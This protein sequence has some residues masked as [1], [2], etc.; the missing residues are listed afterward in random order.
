MSIKEAELEDIG[1]MNALV[2][3][4]GGATLTKATFGN[5]SMNKIIDHS[6]LTL[7]SIE[8][9]T[10]K[11][12]EI[13][14][15]GCLSINDSVSLNEKDSTNFQN[16]VEAIAECIPVTIINT[17]FVNFLIF[18]DKAV[19]ENDCGT[20]LIYEAFLLCPNVD[21][22]IWVCPM[23][24]ITNGFI[25]KTFST[26]TV[27]PKN[28]LLKGNKVLFVH[29]SNF[30]PKLL[31]REALVE[32][33][34][35]LL[36]ILQQ[37]NPD[38]LIDQEHYFLAN[39]IQNQN[40]DNKFYVGLDGRKDEIVGM[41]STSL[42]VNVTLITKIFDSD[43]FPDLV[44]QQEEKP[45]PPPL[46]ISIVG[47]LR[48]IETSMIEEIVIGCECE[49]INASEL[50]SFVD[51]DLLGIAK[52]KDY[53]NK[54]II[55]RANAGQSSLPHAFV[56]LGYPRDE[57]DINNNQDEAVMNYFDMFIELKNVAEDMD[58][59]DENDGFVRHVDALETLRENY[60]KN[61][62]SSIMISTHKTQ[63][64]KIL[65]DNS[66][67]TANDNVHL[68]TSELSRIVYER[69]TQLAAQKA[70][71]ND[72]PPKANAFA[73][74]L[75]CTNNDFKTRGVDLLQI[76]FEEHHD[77]D[78]CLFMCSNNKGPSS[79][80]IP[81][82][83]VN[84]RPGISFDQLLYLMHRSYFVAKEFV[85]V[86]RYDAT[87]L[88]LLSGFVAPQSNDSFNTIPSSPISNPNS[89][90]KNDKNIHG[91][92]KDY[93][94]DESKKACIEQ[95]VDLA[96]N[97][98]DVGFLVK[99]RDTVI[100]YVQL[101]RSTL[102]YE[103]VTWFQ[104]NYDLDRL[105][106][107]DAYR[108]AKSIA[109]I[110]QWIISPLYTNSIRI[111]LQQIMRLYN[112][113]LLLF[114]KSYESTP[115]REIL[116]E[117]TPVN[118]RKKIQPHQSIVRENENTDGLPG[119]AVPLI[120]T[121]PK[122][123]DLSKR[124][125][126]EIGGYD[127]NCP[128]FVISKQIL[129]KSKDI[130]PRRVVIVGGSA[131]SYALLQHLLFIPY[132]YFPNIY[133]IID[134]LPSC[135]RI[136]KTF[137]LFSK[138]SSEDARFDDDLSGCLSIKDVA[139]PTETEL[140]ALGYSH[141]VNLV[142]G[143]IT[144]ID[145]ENKA[146]V[147]SDEAIIEYD[148]LVLSTCLQDNS[149]KKIPLL[150]GLH[151]SKCA[152]MG[153]F[154][155]GNPS[156]DLLALKW[157]RKRYNPNKALETSIMISGTALKVLSAVSKLTKL[158]ISQQRIVA[159]I[160]DYESMMED[161]TDVKIAERI[162]N[163]V[164]VS[165]ITAYWGFKVY[166]VS[167]SKSGFIQ[168]V[169]IQSVLLSED[170]FKEELE[171]LEKINQ[172]E[173]EE[174]ANALMS[175]EENVQTDH[176][177]TLLEPEDTE[178]AILVRPTN[179]FSIACLALLCCNTKQCDRYVFSAVNDSGL[180]YDGGLVVDQY[181][182]TV[183]PFI[184]GVSAFTRFSRMFTNSI[185]HSKNNSAELG[186][187]VGNKILEFHLDPYSPNSVFD[188]SKYNKPSKHIPK[189]LKRNYTDMQRHH[190]NSRNASRNDPASIRSMDSSQS[191]NSKMRSIIDHKQSNII[192]SRVISTASLKGIL[193]MFHDPHSTFVE[194]I[195]DLKFFKSILPDNKLT[196]SAA[197]EGIDLLTLSIEGEELVSHGN[198]CVIQL[199]K[200]GLVAGIE[201]LGYDRIE[202]RNL[203][204]I[205]GLHES[206]L[207]SL[208][209]S[210]DNG[211]ISDFISFLRED[212]AH[213]LYYDRFTQLLNELRDCIKTDKGYLTFLNDV[214]EKAEVTSDNIELSRFRRSLIGAHGEILSEP[215]I[216]TV[217]TTTLKFIHDNKYLLSKYILPHTNT[218]TKLRPNSHSH[219]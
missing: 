18:S 20:K 70:L 5:Y 148:I 205:P 91:L 4:N 7:L 180:V 80:T 34:D 106:H 199:N 210:Y 216:K 204:H 112:K 175:T 185:P 211:K 2:N 219:K 44:V 118:P 116:M 45:I 98:K 95:D 35:D 121:K 173:K 130:I 88:S 43:A 178:V 63:W 139:Y 115:P 31:V 138:Y 144:D 129:Y 28:V 72:E 194:L 141:K 15:T 84:T 150:N 24:L 181:F 125:S 192:P 207:N 105:L 167:L 26:A 29:R 165:G 42:D 154:E 214:L 189:L 197:S 217:E 149:T 10:D 13:K 14:C 97:P 47:D 176:D 166:D 203:H 101:N 134:R 71:D 54:I 137:E 33:N 27:D 100:G 171:I 61:D 53:I 78:Y 83:Y 82:I 62:S 213:L 86:I 69:V 103:D 56:I 23:S 38:A 96:S 25:E 119:K 12:H 157:I 206:F 79:L 190:Y 151:S 187:Y 161:I 17:L 77:K 174:V 179:V 87:M 215:T 133:F 124:P 186:V 110:T 8:H 122:E 60:D 153:V 117:F 209:H 107:V 114:H 152:D 200:V 127:A 73:I 58:E 198:T 75:F 201:F 32:D 51:N 16:V 76:A 68:L 65:I 218:S 146:V 128:L 89:K 155:L 104:G 48:L 131:H 3:A 188:D 108:N 102:T 39:L 49:F 99:I 85:S 126:L 169:I 147:I 136:G 21:F 59:D 191:Q 177:A 163:E 81:F 11:L 6:Y 64:R 142:K 93:I 9:T 41:L 55:D 92:D 145:R 182:R 22:I 212:W 170:S 40:D 67:N 140:F 184:F 30:L 143:V 123:T 120:D 111:I 135:F 168:N 159:V 158:G 156:A 57:N 193:P 19:L 208:Q 52:V 46:L 164:Q 183:D 132:L 66:M 90:L 36:P 74:T 37:F 202:E 196:T 113:D 172:K 94:M 109:M 1:L 160:S 195:N 50:N 162:V